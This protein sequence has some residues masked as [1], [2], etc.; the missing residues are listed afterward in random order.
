MTSSNY[1]NDLDY[2]EFQNIIEISKG[3]ISIVC[4]A[5]YAKHNIRVALKSLNPKELIQEVKYLFC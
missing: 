2:D 3:E 1:T 5:D 4:K